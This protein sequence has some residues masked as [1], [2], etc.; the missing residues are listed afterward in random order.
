[1]AAA[2]TATGFL[3]LNIAG[4]DKAISTAKKAL[5]A[6][7]AVFAVFKTVNFWKEG[8]EGAINFGNEIYHA[9]QRLGAMDPG[10]LLIA[11][12]MLENAG[13]GAE[14]ARTQINELI[15]SQRS[16]ASLFAGTTDFAQ[17][18]ENATASYGSQAKVLSENAER[19]SKVFEIIQSVGSK[20]QTFFLAMT[21]RFV[22]PLLAVLNFLN[23]IDLAGIGASI[24]DGI[25]KAASFLVGMVIN[26]N[27]GEILGLSLK[28]GFM[29]A[30]DYL[31]EKLADI[32]EILK[33]F[34]FNSKIFDSI[35]LIFKGIAELIGATLKGAIA[36][37]LNGITIAGIPLLS[38]ERKEQL[39]AESYMSAKLGH[40]MIDRGA[41]DLES[42]GGILGG[43]GGFIK[44]LNTP[45]EGAADK[46]SGL[47]ADALKAGEDYI[48]KGAGNQSKAKGRIEAFGA[49]DP[50]KVI[51]SSMAKIGGGG[52]YMVQ[53][54]TIE[55]RF[56][57]RKLAQQV[58]TNELIVKQTVAIEKI[59]ADKMKP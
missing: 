1:M 11:Q 6:L 14:G 24:G 48:T 16:M 4:F 23:S 36:S 7:T 32:V 9:S 13:L 59:G 21:A 26:G 25:A 42:Q 10:K 31:T 12:K 33:K 28:V 37:A 17:A 15:D 51:A 45:I 2:A 58:I 43:I 46:L 41:K 30:T 19:L 40:K 44:R 18:L 5:V 29:M 57:M 22:T 54:M 20:L 27:I 3:E 8:I 38:D 55:A 52:G 47:V 49:Q 34:K 35:V 39:T 53:G 56:S 50:Y